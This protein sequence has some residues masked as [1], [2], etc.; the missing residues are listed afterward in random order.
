M[1]HQASLLL[2]ALLSSSRFSSPALTL[3]C[4]RK[5]LKSI[6]CRSPRPHPSALRIHA[7][8]PWRGTLLHPICSSFGTIEGLAVICIA[9][10]LYCH[11]WKRREIWLLCEPMFWLKI[12]VHD[13][14]GERASCVWSCGS[15]VAYVADYN[16]GNNAWSWFR[17]KFV[18][19]F[20]N[21][22]R[23]FTCQYFAFLFLR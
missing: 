23:R 1:K 11:T 5:M 6:D 7:Q 19:V 3:L 20:G 17:W 15:G 12:R 14:D 16:D 2:E 8:S 18:I 10:W 13:H 22:E 9:C 4:C 21:G